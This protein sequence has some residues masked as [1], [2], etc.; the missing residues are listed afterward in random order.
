MPV[1]DEVCAIHTIR[2]PARICAL[3]Q[4]V[5]VLLNQTSEDTTIN[6]IELRENLIHVYYGSELN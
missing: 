4:R 3:A 6:G 5:L 2:T 1:C